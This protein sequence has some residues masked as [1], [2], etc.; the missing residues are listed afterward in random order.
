MRTPVCVA[1]LAALW[2]ALGGVASA[3][4]TAPAPAVAP[5]AAP[6]G[7]LVVAL[8]GAER[9]A[10]ELAKAVYGRGDLRPAID[11]ATARVLVGEPASALS[12]PPGQEA[13]I[14]ELEALVA[15][16]P[17]NPDDGETRR[18][19]WSLGRETNAA[20]V[21]VVTTS[22]GE[23]PRTTAR[24]LDVAEGTYSAVELT[25]RPTGAEGDDGWSGAAEAIDGLLPLTAEP[26]APVVAP[27]V[28][29]PPAK[30]V[31]PPA[32]DEDE[33]RSWYENPWFWGSTGAVAAVGVTVLVL[34]VTTQDDVD[35]VRLQGRAPE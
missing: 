26:T 35:S 28:T 27:I 34:A 29:A 9:P 11:D 6:R 3:D 15:S 4:V 1:V 23:P 17:P 21:V 20:L 8:R 31:A 14:R 13:R 32:P 7:A 2:S 10:W 19:V 24:I 18:A 30:S 5:V 12:P 22:E 16:I 25:H 33:G